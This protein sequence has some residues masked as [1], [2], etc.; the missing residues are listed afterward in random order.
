MVLEDFLEYPT[1]VREWA[2]QK[3]FY[4]AKQFSEMTGKRT[5]WPGKRTQHVVDLD[6][7]YADVILGR[8]AHLANRHFG[9]TNISIRS[10]FQL[11]TAEDGDSWVHQD[12]D[13]ELAAVLYL[14]PVSPVNSGTSIYRC[15]DVK[16]WE[17]F[18]ATGQGYE[19]L[20][21]INTVDNKDL[22]DQ[23]F[24]PTMNVESVFNR[25]IIYNGTEYHKS[26]NYFGDSPQTGRLTQVFFIK[27]EA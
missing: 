1:V 5:D 6:A 15:K 19:T 4:N 16:R 21:T 17:S 13:T 20:K 27:S 8:V 18:M 24:E 10:Y 9:I 11:T 26:N 12:N 3:E 2:L 23:L 7:R 25:L 14:N 22:L